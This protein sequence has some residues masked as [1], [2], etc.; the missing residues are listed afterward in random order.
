[1][2]INFDAIAEH[3]SKVLLNNI[4]ISKIATAKYIYIK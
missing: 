4:K 3:R 1:M 2:T